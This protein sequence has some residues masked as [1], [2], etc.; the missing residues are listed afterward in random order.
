MVDDL[1]P[2]VV[3]GRKLSPVEFCLGQ[4][5]LEEVAAEQLWGL[6]V[7]PPPDAVAAYHQHKNG[8]TS[9]PYHFF[10]THSLRSLV[11]SGGLSWD[12]VMK[13][14]PDD[15]TRLALLDAFSTLRRGV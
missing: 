3:E 10:A 4:S 2:G 8:S 14:S 7:G 1:S 11:Q 9:A 5:V 12:D 6:G 15:T 13:G